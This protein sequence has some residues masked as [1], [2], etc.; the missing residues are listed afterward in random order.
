MTARTC[1]S[2]EVSAETMAWEDC[3]GRDGDE[4]GVIM[5]LGWEMR[6]TSYLYLG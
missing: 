4:M 3:G 1:T 6:V 2:R 5:T